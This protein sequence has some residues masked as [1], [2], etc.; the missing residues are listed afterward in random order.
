MSFFA[1]YYHKDRFPPVAK[2]YLDDHLSGLM[3]IKYDDDDQVD[4]SGDDDD[5]DDDYNEQ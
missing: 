2:N 3:T 1:T 5:K 4:A